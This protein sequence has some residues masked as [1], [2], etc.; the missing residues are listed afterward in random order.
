MNRSNT[1]QGHRMSS[2]KARQMVVRK[3]ARSPNVIC[4][5]TTDGGEEDCSETKHD[6]H[7]FNSERSN[8]ELPKPNNEFS[9]Y[10]SSRLMLTLTSPNQRRAPFLADQSASS[11]PSE[12]VYKVINEQ[13]CLR[14]SHCY[15]AA[16]LNKQSTTTTMS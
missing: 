11:R 4:Q 1:E 9:L 10:S 2:V 6:E 8:N 5:G 12:L 3:I 7:P 13:Q 15:S 16:S 14:Y